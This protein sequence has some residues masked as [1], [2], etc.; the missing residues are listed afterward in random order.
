MSDSDG[1]LDDMRWLSNIR[2]TD[3]DRLLDGGAPVDERLEGV[4][5][6]LQDLGSVFPEEPTGDLESAHVAAMVEEARL[7]DEGIPSSAGAAI[8]RK[9][10]STP[11]SRGGWFA[12]RPGTTT[13]ARR[14][15]SVTALA[16]AGLL[17]F[18]G[19]AY[20]GV[21][22]EPIQRAVSDAAR[23]VGIAI[24]SPRL[25]HRSVVGD[26]S[27]RGARGADKGRRGASGVDKAAGAGK[28]VGTTE[29]AN[30]LGSVTTSTPA[31]RRA[32]GTETAGAAKARRGTAGK[33]AAEKA[34][35]VRPK[36]GHAATGSKVRKPP[37]KHKRSKETPPRNVTGQTPRNS[38]GTDETQ[39]DSGKR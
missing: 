5:R 16:M 35:A 1:Y 14:F 31:P 27:G 21:L 4:A 19:A 15:T 23:S 13:G 34:K 12:P 30:G 18:G 10:S 39:L 25:T 38:K 3:I 24:P 17:A 2:D 33:R 8:G 20:A 9:A 32:D 26:R 28:A 29:T 11:R 36:R 22:P 7:A 6:F 37:S